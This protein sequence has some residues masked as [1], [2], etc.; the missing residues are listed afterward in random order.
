MFFKE[1][2]FLPMNVLICLYNSLFSPVLQF[3]LLVWGL[4]YKAYTNP[5]FL[6]Q[7]MVIRAIAFENYI[8]QSTPTFSSL[9]FLNCMISSNYNFRPLFMNLFIKSP[10]FVSITFLNLWHL[11]INIVLNRQTR[12]IFLAQKNTQ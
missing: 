11:F 1:R 3:G 10:L 8:S 7:K 12:V 5:V 9:Q 6:L 2:H 4:T